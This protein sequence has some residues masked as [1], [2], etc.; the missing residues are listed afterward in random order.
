MYR[1]EKEEQEI[2]DVL[3]KCDEQEDLGSSKWPGMTYEQGVAQGIRWVLGHWD[4][5]PMED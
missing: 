5:N 4:T 3:N 2:D 1:V